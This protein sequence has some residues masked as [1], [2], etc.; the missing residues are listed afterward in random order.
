M[1]P[2]TFKNLGYPYVINKTYFQP[3]GAPH[4]WPQCLNMMDW[5]GELAAFHADMRAHL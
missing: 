5:L 1:L 4:T 2:D 3:V